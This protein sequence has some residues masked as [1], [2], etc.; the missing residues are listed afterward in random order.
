MD[1][2]ILN[3]DMAEKIE[4][5]E[6]EKLTPYDKNARTHSEDQVKKI[7]ASMTQFGFTNPILVDSN[8]G[9]IAGHGRL[10]AAKILGLAKVPVIILDH[11][12]EQQKRAYV[13][14]D[15]RLA[16]DAGWDPTLLHEELKWLD[17][18]EFDLELTGF[19]EEELSAILEPTVIEP[20]EDED[21]VPSLPI[22]SKTKVHVLN[23]D[24]D[25]GLF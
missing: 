21:K 9:I 7:A 6:V 12:N 16:L 11:L 13:L 15:N 24:F 22:E 20:Q 1:T 17:D 25:I 4:L 8:T 18:Q 2:D 14:A 5:W 19:S 10:Q 23:T 3:I